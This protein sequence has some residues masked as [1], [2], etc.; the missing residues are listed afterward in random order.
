MYKFSIFISFGGRLPEDCGGLT[1]G[2]YQKN[3]SF[4]FPEQTKMPKDTDSIV[5]ADKRLSA[6]AIGV[7]KLDLAV[8]VSECGFSF[9][10]ASASTGEYLAAGHLSLPLGGSHRRLL[11]KMIRF[12][13][14]TAP[15][16]GLE[17]RQVD[18][19]YLDRDFTLVPGELFDREKA[20]DLLS[21]AMGKDLRDGVL[22]EIVEQAVCVFYSRE[23]I[24]R[25]FATKTISVREHHSAAVFLRRA[26]LQRQSGRCVHANFSDGYLQ[27]AVT[28]GEKLIL[29]NVFR[30]ERRED[31]MYYLLLTANQ[32]G[33]DV[34]HVPFILYGAP[35]VY[36]K[37]MAEINRCLANYRFAGRCPS[38]CFSPALDFV[39]G[40]E[41]YNLLGGKL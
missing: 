20:A 33:T 36:L 14:T 15:F 16:S 11:E 30:I 10:L 41:Y 13:E 5:Y 29:D 40:Y 17:Y 31:F 28:E 8:E 22:H 32:T 39:A 19:V 12:F 9:S 37:N 27:V 38:E 24:V 1:D 4:V 26:F 18:L 21:F 3:R 6:P 35:E 2:C 7:E 25:Y 34:S 23:D